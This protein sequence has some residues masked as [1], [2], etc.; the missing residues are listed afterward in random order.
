MV[1]RTSENGGRKCHKYHIIG[2]EVEEC[3]IRKEG[4]TMSSRGEEMVHENQNHVYFEVKGGGRQ[5]LRHVDG[6]FPSCMRKTKKE[7]HPDDP[8]YG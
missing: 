4:M 8:E 6:D 3:T 1:V 2:K 5:R 7:Q